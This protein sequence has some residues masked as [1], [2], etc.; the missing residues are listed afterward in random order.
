MKRFWE[1]LVRPLL[2][3]Y[4]PKLL[5]EI[6]SYRGANTELVLT[7]CR[8]HDAVL[9]AVDPLPQFDVAAWQIEFG[10][11]FKFHQTKSLKII[12]DLPPAD[13]VLLDGDHNWYTV[14]H[15]LKQLAE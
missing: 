1:S 12:R 9:H 2:E 13:L 7:Y 15:E 8:D 14:Y 6:G 11:H 5:L 3:Q 10:P 4:D